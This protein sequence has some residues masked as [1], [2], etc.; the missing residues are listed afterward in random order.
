MIEC[1]LERYYPFS[2]PIDLYEAIESYIESF[3][4]KCSSISDYQRE[5]TDAV[6][7]IAIDFWRL[8]PTWPEPDFT[9]LLGAMRWCISAEKVRQGEPPTKTK[10]KRANKKLQGHI[11]E[12]QKQL[13]GSTNSKH[14]AR[15]IAK[16][17]PE[18]HKPKPETITRT[19]NRMRAKANKN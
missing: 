16:N 5:D 6:L 14:I 12:A 19:M 9:N 8:H 1:E 13:L 7:K 17:H 15:Q 4:F 3:A 2:K 11:T 18:Y 10:P